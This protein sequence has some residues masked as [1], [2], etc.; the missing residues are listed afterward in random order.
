VEKSF[1]QFPG[2]TADILRRNR[3]DAIATPK[4]HLHRTR[5]G[6]RHTA[7]R[8]MEDS[9]DLFPAADPPPTRRTATEA[10]VAA[11]SRAIAFFAKQT[12]HE[13][14]VPAFRQRERYCAG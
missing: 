3:P 8:L 2:L 12:V 14:Q 9:S 11:N 5:Q 10:F 6:L 13:T 7:A 4:G 1:V